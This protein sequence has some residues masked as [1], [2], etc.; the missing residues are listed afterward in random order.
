MPLPQNSLTKDEFETLMSYITLQ[1]GGF[2]DAQGYANSGLQF[3]VLLQRVT[4]EV[5]LIGPH[6]S[7]FLN[8]EALNTTAHWT[9]IVNTINNHLATRGTSAQAAETLSARLNRWLWCQGS[10]VTS[11]YKT[12][13]DDSGWD[14]DWCNVRGDDADP[15][16][17]QGEL[18]LDE[19]GN[20][21][22]IGCTDLSPYKDSPPAG[23]G[24]PTT[25]G[26]P[27]GTVSP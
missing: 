10:R 14:I 9:Q 4:P 26:D 17:Q 3:V 16:S 7:H 6:A 20:P 12:I 21:I 22:A 19:E 2:D 15:D 18:I 5:D 27:I 13:S 11:L 23:V 8:I 1:K 24:C 25:G